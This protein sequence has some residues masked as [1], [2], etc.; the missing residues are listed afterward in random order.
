MLY[1]IYN[2]VND[3]YF[4]CNVV[5]DFIL[6]KIVV[7]NFFINYNIVYYVIFKL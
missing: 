5:N 4:N 2:V 3:F 7:N 6:F 1:F